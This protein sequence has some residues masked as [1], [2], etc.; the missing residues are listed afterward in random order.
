MPTYR[1]QYDGPRD[2]DISREIGVD[3]ASNPIDPPQFKDYT[4][5]SEADLGVLTESLGYKGYRFI[6][7]V[8]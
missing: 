4:I 8:T 7:E 1:Y 3:V 2:I 5:D 6:A